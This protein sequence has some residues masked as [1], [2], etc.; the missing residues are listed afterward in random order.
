MNVLLH[1]KEQLGL[2]NQQNKVWLDQF[3]ADQTS[4]RKWNPDFINDFRKS[5][6]YDRDDETQSSCAAAQPG[7]L[8][9]QVETHSPGSRWAWWKPFLPGQKNPVGFQ[10]WRPGLQYTP[11]LFRWVFFNEM[12]W[13]DFFYKTES[14]SMFHCCELNF[15]MDNS[16]DVPTNQT[17][18]NESSLV[19]CCCCLGGTRTCN[20]TALRKS[21]NISDLQALNSQNSISAAV[22]LEQT[23]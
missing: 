22:T 15:W 7:F 12:K 1:L 8:T 14:D 19:C 10:P 11:R 9:N 17:N 3:D 18:Q 21:L 4:E 13:G 20:H 23:A 5:G 16:T 2:W 6:T